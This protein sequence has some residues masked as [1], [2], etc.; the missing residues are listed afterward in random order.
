MSLCLTFFNS[1]MRFDQM[2]AKSLLALNSIL[3]SAGIRIPHQLPNGPMALGRSFDTLCCHLT[4]DVFRSCYGFSSS[5][6]PVDKTP[7]VIC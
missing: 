2:I 7:A 4:L 5:T 3:L 6:Q 1:D